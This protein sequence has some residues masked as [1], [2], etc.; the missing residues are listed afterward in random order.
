[1]NYSKLPN[2]FGIDE[3]LITGLN[4]LGTDHDATVD[5]V[6]RIY[7]DANLVFNKKN[8]VSDAP[9]LHSLLGEII[10]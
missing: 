9:A 6:L 4:D 3:I 7:R 10:L 2:V 5:K 8:V 1:M